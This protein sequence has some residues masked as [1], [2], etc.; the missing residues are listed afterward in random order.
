VFPSVGQERTNLERV[1]WLPELRV[2][3]GRRGRRQR[4]SKDPPR[5][6]DLDGVTIFEDRLL[7]PLTVQERPIRGPEILERPVPAMVAEP[8]VHAR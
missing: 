4:F 1:A 6:P 7:H 5:A 3:R 2:E 8:D